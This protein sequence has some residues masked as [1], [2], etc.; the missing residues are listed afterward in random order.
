MRAWGSLGVLIP[1]RRSRRCACFSSRSRACFCECILRNF[2]MSF[3]GIGSVRASGVHLGW[4]ESTR[5]FRLRVVVERPKIRHQATA[6]GRDDAVVLREAFAAGPAK[7][8]PHH[9]SC[10][11]SSRPNR[12]RPVVASAVEPCVGPGTRVHGI[13]LDF[14]VVL[15]ARRSP[16]H[17]NYAKLRAGPVAAAP[18]RADVVAVSSENHG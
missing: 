11:H 10:K 18:R 4:P 3:L 12:P 8:D 1:R 14:A 2:R 6:G 16:A 17:V 13:C 15:R 7:R 5:Q 9:P